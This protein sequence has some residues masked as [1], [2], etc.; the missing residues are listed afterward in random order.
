MRI[1][2]RPDGLRLA[3]AMRDGATPTIVFLPGY[4]SDMTGTKALAL[5]AWAGAEGRAML[6]FD[7]GG[8]GASE[9][10]FE[11]QTLD[12]WLDDALIAIDRLTQGPLVL[13]GSSMGGWMALLV[14][15]ARPA[16]VAALI[17]IAAAPDFTDWGFGADDV[18]TLRRDGRLEV[19]SVY[20]DQLSVTTRALW[21]SGARHLLLDAPIAIDAPV[22]LLHGQADGDVPY[23]VSL[24]IAEQVRSADVQTILVKDGDH[25][26]SRD[27]DIA[28]LLQTVASVISP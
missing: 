9:G 7:Y 13:V 2:T 5:D 6:R 11:D 20:S 18:A 1:L 23:T 16:R 14:A 21:E 22:R 3:H 19:P 25:R 28:L 24:R 10:A 8:C 15:L 4:A 26:L 17:G 27:A 12:D